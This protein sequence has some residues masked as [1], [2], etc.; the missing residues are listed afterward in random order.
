[1]KPL[2]SLVCAATA[3]LFAACVTESTTKTVVMSGDMT[4]SAQAS[5]THRASPER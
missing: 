5:D 3:L 2:L 4:T 1:M